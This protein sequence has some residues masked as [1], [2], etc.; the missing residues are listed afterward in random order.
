MEAHRSVERFEHG[1]RNV[2]GE[3]DTPDFA[4]QAALLVAV[5]AALLAIATFLSNES[6][7]EVITGETQ[8]ADASSRLESNQLKIDVAGGNST[9]LRVLG[10][11]SGNEGPAARA[12]RAHEARI[13]E[14][15][16]PA[17]HHINE[18]ID[19]DAHEV[20]H[21]NSKHLLYELAEV[22]LEVGIVLSTVSIIAKR[23]WLLGG[24]VGVAL[25]GTV[26]LLIGALAV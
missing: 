20:D 17:D 19:H 5:M 13:H 15:L 2:A 21:Y 8:R 10:E 14:E 22:A 26:L 25:I 12:A 11:G 23:R 4:R 7:K 9:L 16:E 18:E 1:H 24:G 6:V 3:L